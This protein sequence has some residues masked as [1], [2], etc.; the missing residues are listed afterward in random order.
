MGIVMD[1]SRVVSKVFLKKSRGC[2]AASPNVKRLLAKLISSFSSSSAFY[3]PPNFLNLTPASLAERVFSFMYSDS[4]LCCQEKSDGAFEKEN[5][6]RSSAR[7][8]S[9]QN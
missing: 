5:A 1:R 8:P 7:R 6:P 9:L 4:G 2:I 3:S